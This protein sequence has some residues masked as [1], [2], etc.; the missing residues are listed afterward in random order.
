VCDGHWVAGGAGAL[1]GGVAGVLAGA[2]PGIGLLNTLPSGGDV[3]DPRWSFALVSVPV[4]AV[5]GGIARSSAGAWAATAL[6]A[7]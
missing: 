4:G 3:V 7:P 2:A 1:F 5:V 6:F